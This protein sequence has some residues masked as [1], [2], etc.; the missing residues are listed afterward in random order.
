MSERR[1]ALCLLAVRTRARARAAQSIS[2]KERNGL[3]LRV[4][5]YYCFVVVMFALPILVHVF[6]LFGCDAEG[7][8]RVHVQGRPMFRGSR[9]TLFLDFSRMPLQAST[10]SKAPEFNMP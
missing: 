3:L 4:F 10:T 6:L 7:A 9:V 5:L 8:R 1:V 2:C